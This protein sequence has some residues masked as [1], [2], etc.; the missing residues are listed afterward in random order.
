MLDIIDMP[1]SLDAALVKVS[2][3]APEIFLNT[4]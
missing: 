4:I 3:N 2:R 1:R